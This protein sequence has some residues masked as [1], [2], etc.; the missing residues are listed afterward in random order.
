MSQRMHKRVSDGGGERKRLG[1][2]EAEKEDDMEG[3]KKTRRRA[4]SEEDK[5]T[6]W[7]EENKAAVMGRRQQ[8]CGMERRKQGGG[9][10]AKKGGTQ[11]EKTA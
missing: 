5:A 8:G 9:H 11:G 2:R 4:W 3:A 6:A 7:S 10:G 1:G